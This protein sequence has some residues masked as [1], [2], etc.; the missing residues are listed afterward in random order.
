MEFGEPEIVQLV[1]SVWD[2]MLGWH[3]ERAP[4]PGATGT[5]QFL[6]GCVPITGAW[7][8]GV[9]LHCHDEL[10]RAAA[11]T[12]FAL[13]PAE[14]SLE[15]KQDALGELT[16]IIGGNLKALFSG[17]CH[18]GLP[19]VAS[20]NDYELRVVASRS[21]LRVGFRC[22]QLPFIVEVCECQPAASGERGA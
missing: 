18:L 12:I 11:A 7:S 20:G 13:P 1:E 8:G 10:A 14:V 5:E 2:S 4:D 17:K 3:V 21:L 19:A 9:L 22:Q 15:M 6:T 16:N